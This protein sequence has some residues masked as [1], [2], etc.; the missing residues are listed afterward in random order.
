[1]NV[2]STHSYIFLFRRASSRVVTYSSAFP[3]ICVVVTTK[4]RV[5]C[6]AK[7]GS[8]QDSRECLT[9]VTRPDYAANFSRTIAT[10]HG[11]SLVFHFDEVF[12]AG[13]PRHCVRNG[14]SGA[15]PVF[16][17]QF[18]RQMRVFTLRHSCKYRVNIPLD[19]NKP[20]G[21]RTRSEGK[22]PCVFLDEA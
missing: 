2:H 13:R 12:L 14:S 22:F 4:E 15:N 10:Q 11:R 21:Y 8:V 17:E 16:V 9:T 7:L 6:F 1:M 5:D 3:S 19:C 18:S 20:F